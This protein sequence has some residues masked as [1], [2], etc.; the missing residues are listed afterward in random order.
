MTRGSF[1]RRERKERKNKLIF[2]FLVFFAVNN[3]LY[4]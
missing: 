2:V 1:Y 3:I 4:R